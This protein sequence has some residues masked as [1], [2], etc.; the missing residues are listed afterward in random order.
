MGDANG[1][2]KSFYLVKDNHQ[3]WKVFDFQYVCPEKAN[4]PKLSSADFLEAET[5]C[6]KKSINST[7]DKI[8]VKQLVI[9]KTL[10]QQRL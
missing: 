8:Y 5:D 9:I 7:C 6:K 4:A 1:S 3:F 2:L 10:D